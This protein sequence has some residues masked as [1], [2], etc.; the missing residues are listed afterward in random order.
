ME[1]SIYQYNKFYSF[2]QNDWTALHLCAWNGYPK[3]CQKL[4]QVGFH[5]DSPGPGHITA[6]SL[7]CQKGHLNIVNL[8]IQAHCNINSTADID[9]NEDVSALHFAA[10]HGHVE[11]VKALLSAGAHVNVAMTT[12]GINGV[13]PLHLAVEA[14]H[15]DVMDVL[16]DAGCDI[17]SSTRAPS[18]TLC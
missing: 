11:I 1:I 10:Q 3:I 8:L 16:I 2:F 12:R 13:T 7:A 6:L 14:G 17:Q 15:M 4:L 9:T 5:V 18:E